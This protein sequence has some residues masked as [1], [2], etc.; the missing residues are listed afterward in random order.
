MV[1]SG[2]RAATLSVITS[3]GWQPGTSL[4]NS[5]ALLLHRY[6][7]RPE[8]LVQQLRLGRYTVDFAAPDIQIVIEADGWYH[9]SPEGAARDAER[10]SWLRLKGWVVLRVDDRNGADSLAEQVAR[11]VR[12]MRGEWGRQHP[13]RPARE[14]LK[15]GGRPSWG[16]HDAGAKAADVNAHVERT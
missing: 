16:H 7:V 13:Q 15:R 14:T 2:I 5:V 4:E 11:A 12:L 6:K 8:D 1:N 3:H 9:R 10:D